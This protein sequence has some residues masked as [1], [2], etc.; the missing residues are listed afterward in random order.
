MIGNVAPMELYGEEFS[1]SALGVARV[2]VGSAAIYAALFKFVFLKIRRACTKLTTAPL[3][4]EMAV[5]PQC[6][7]Y[8]MSS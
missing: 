2:G 5:V 6:V 7:T 1:Y 8:S 4:M 3:L